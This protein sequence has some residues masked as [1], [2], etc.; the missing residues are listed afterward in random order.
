MDLNYAGKP[1]R[2]WWDDE[3]LKQELITRVNSTEWHVKFSDGT[4]GRVILIC[5]GGYKV[6]LPDGTT[7]L[8]NPNLC[9]VVDISDDN[10]TQLVDLWQAKQIQLTQEK[11][12]RAAKLEAERVALELFQSNCLHESSTETEV[13]RHPACD[14]TD[15]TCN[16][17]NKLLRKSWSTNNDSDPNDHVSDWEWW[18]REHQKRYG[19]LPK[20]S[21][22]DVVKVITGD[23]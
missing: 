21:N 19:S 10:Y 3:N 17:C 11:A 18:C 5:W 4:P 1:L 8:T 6:Q 2:P 16:T 23:R 13:M 14:I 20:R 9:E 22:Y 15:T 7:R 12:E